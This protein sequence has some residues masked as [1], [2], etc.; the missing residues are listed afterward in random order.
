LRIARDI[1]DDLSAR[2]THISLL[3]ARGEEEAGAE[4]TRAI[5]EQISG[6]TRNLV[7]ALHE[8]IWAVNPEND[9]AEALVN[10]LCQIA[11]ELCESASLRCR[12]HVPPQLPDSSPIAS[13]VRHQ[14][15]MTVREAIHN[16]VKHAHAQELVLSF[17][18]ENSVLSITVRDDGRGF[19][20]AT[21]AQGNGLGNMR[22]RLEEIGGTVAIE[23]SEGHGT[24]MILNLEL[25]G[26]I[27]I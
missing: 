27:E 2:A 4:K 8:T 14:I 20:P 16:A 12:L 6:V 25:S 23:S 21:A 7:F 18:I 9:N 13:D 3:S 22:R 5:F 15:T 11:N 19:I 26:K 24:A 1:H 17:V 10:H